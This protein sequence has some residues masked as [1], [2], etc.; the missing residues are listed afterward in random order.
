MEILV[1]T[2]ADVW[3]MPIRVSLMTCEFAIASGANG[4][5]RCRTIRDLMLAGF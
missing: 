1:A 5:W 3:Q 4:T 2:T